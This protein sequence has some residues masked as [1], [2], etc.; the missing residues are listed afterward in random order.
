MSYD[1]GQTERGASVRLPRLGRG[2]RRDTRPGSAES[3]QAGAEFGFSVAT[4]GDVNGDG[5]SDVIVGAH[6]YDN[7][8]AGEGRAFVYHGSAAGLDTTPAWTAE[9]NQIS[10]YSAARWRPPGT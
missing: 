8:E 9:S 5:Y 1:G 2:A 10:A 3:N 6:S 4:A 7:G